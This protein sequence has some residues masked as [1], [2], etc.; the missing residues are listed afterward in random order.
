MERA[1]TKL[2]E[3]RR[4]AR[5]YVPRALGGG[6]SELRQVELLDLSPTGARIE[7]REHLHEGLMCFV[8]LP[9]AFGR[10]RLTGRVVWTRLH[11]GEQT[12]EGARHHYY[13]SG[14][15]FTGLTPAQRSAL[16][17]ALRTLQARGEAAE[18]APRGG[19]SAA[20]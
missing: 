4:V 11:K 15:T 14:L 5:L 19:T 16:T 13:Q 10:L 18:P 20:E 1:M 7:H 12:L 2:R 3:R 8:D 6:E 9:R 17:A